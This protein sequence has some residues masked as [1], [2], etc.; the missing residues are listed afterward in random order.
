MF[1]NF[2]FVNCLLIFV[3]FEKSNRN[4]VDGIFYFFLELFD[5]F[6]EKCIFLMLVLVKS[7]LFLFCRFFVFCWKFK[8]FLILILFEI[9]IV[10]E[11]VLD[12][13]VVSEFLFIYFMILLIFFGFFWLFDW[14]VFVS[15]LLGILWIIFEGSD[16]SVFWIFIFVCVCLLCINFFFSLFCF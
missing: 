16:E 7:V 5:F 15:V 9:L 11:D 12:F 3:V 4:F 14:N 10:V 6:N 1:N 2:C 13:N 8:F